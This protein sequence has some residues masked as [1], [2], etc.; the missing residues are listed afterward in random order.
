MK[1][2]FIGGGNMAAALIG[3][4][5]LRAQP[6]DE[7]LVVE[8]DAARRSLLERDFGVAT[9]ASVDASIQDST[10]V[11]L[12]VKPVD[13]QPVCESLGRLPGRYLVLSIAAGIP[14]TAIARWCGTEAVVRAMPNTPALIGQGITGLCARSGASAEQRIAAA[15]TM[16]VIGEAIW[17][18]DEAMLDAVTA[19]SGSGPAYVFYFIEALQ[20]AAKQMGMD[21]QQARHFAVQTFVGAAQLA[22]RSTE[23]IAVLRERVTS[24][25]GTTAAALEKLGQADVGATI[26]AAAFAALERSR[27]LARTYAG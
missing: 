23:D 15:R 26:I 6:D 4:L 21:A 12:A 9:R 1:L 14:S 22:A 13:I 2:G 18:N 11:L 5:R 16:Q 25:G 20:D 3:G 7:I 24:K 17:F 27:E 8:R 10:I 19:I